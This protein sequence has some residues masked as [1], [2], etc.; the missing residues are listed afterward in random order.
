MPPEDE[1]KIGAFLE[2]LFSKDKVELPPMVRPEEK[3]VDSS[4]LSRTKVIDEYKKAWEALSSKGMG[5][6]RRIDD[7]AKHIVDE[8]SM[9][10]IHSADIEVQ[11]QNLWNLLVQRKSLATA[12]L[13]N[14]DKSKREFI[15]RSVAETE[16]NIIRILGINISGLK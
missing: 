14:P 13:D 12:F 9:T 2:R 1:N 11:T 3:F 6:E 10:A 4:T 5:I 16:Y 7:S 15:L 8:Y